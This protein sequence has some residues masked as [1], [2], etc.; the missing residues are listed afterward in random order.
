MLDLLLIG[1]LNSH[2]GNGFCALQFFRLH[3]SLC[4]RLI[5]ANWCSI[6]VMLNNGSFILKG[7]MLRCEIS[8]TFAYDLVE[9]L[10]TPAEVISE[11]VNLL[12]FFNR[13]W[14]PLDGL[15]L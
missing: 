15:S 9:A 7:E 1:V 10:D 3:Q 13:Y 14:A 6:E 11:D 4:R 2:G 8:A 5:R 12:L